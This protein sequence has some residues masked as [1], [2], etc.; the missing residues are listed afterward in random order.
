LQKVIAQGGY[1]RRTGVK[2]RKICGKYF[3]ELLTKE[4]LEKYKKTKTGVNYDVK[5][6]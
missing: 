1:K 4:N 2:H 5:S 6:E 3:F